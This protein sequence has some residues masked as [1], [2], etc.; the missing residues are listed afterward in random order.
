MGFEK[1]KKKTNFASD[2]NVLKAN[3]SDTQYSFSL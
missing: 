1:F 2:Q 3:S